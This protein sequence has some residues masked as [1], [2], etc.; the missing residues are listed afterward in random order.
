MASPPP[1]ID[2]TEARRRQALGQCLLDLREPVEWAAGSP[3][4]ALR[5][6]GSELLAQ[7]GEVL[8]QRERPILL[9]C[10]VGARAQ[11]CVTGLRALGYTDLTVVAGGFVAWKAAGLDVEVPDDA[12]AAWRRRY[13]RQIVL[14]E[15]GEAG[16]RRL[17]A[18]RVLVIGAGGLGSPAALYLAAAGI[19]QMT[20]VDDDLVDESNLQRQVLHSTERI[21]RRKV[22]SAAATL[23]ALNPGLDLHAVPE[24]VSSSNVDALVGA[25][26]LILDG[27]DN[28]PTRYLLSDA[29]VLHAKPLVYGAVERFVGQVS[30]FHPGSAR[31]TAP[32]YRCLFPQPPSPEEAPNCAEVGV[33]GVVPGLIGMLQATEAIKLILG[34]GTPLIGRLLIVDALGTRMRELALSADPECP[35]CAPGTPFPGYIDYAAF[36]RADVAGPEPAR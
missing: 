17:Q 4:D 7:I 1:Q 11:N 23:L 8:P 22:D 6:A 30:V 35:V 10:A 31:G 2:V 32:C 18:A 15:V 5:L 14:A 24:R 19:G 26:D 16:Q 33:L 13:A 20:L 28:L 34:I 21:G 29:A 25:C 27:S 9:L 12:D 3:P 36:C